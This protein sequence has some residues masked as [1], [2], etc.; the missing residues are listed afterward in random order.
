LQDDVT[1]G[2]SIALKIMT[3]ESEYQDALNENYNTL[4]ETTFKSL[5]RILPV[6][7]NKI[8]WNKVNLTAY[9]CLTKRRLQHLNSAP[10]WPTD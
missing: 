7:R 8:D 10:R 9:C 2:S 5:R 6:T 4:S 3:T 1:T